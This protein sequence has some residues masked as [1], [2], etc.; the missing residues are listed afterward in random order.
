MEEGTF[1]H[2]LSGDRIEELQ[3][4]R[5]LCYVGMTRA[6]ERLYLTAARVRKLYGRSI[7]RDV[8]S[9]IREIPSE[10]LEYRE[11][12]VPASPAAPRQGGAGGSA[13]GAGRPRQGG[14]RRGAGGGTGRPA[15]GA[16]GL[17]HRLTEEQ[18]DG[19]RPGDRI[20]H[21]QFGAGSVVAVTGGVA[22]IR[23]D[24]GKK[25]RFMLRYTPLTREEAGRG[26]GGRAEE[27]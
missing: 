18:I 26:P 4:E 12:G 25:M 16:S 23:F 22:D 19:I 17:R 6:M 13:G 11:A 3:E 14:E 21:R 7:E 1:P 10:L 20:R 2:H 5:R 27:G 9:F 24:D 8:S 15:A